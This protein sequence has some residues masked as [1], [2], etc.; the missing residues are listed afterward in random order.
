MNI[1]KE[2]DVI[3]LEYK[4][5][6]EGKYMIMLIDMCVSAINEVLPQCYK[7]NTMNGLRKEFVIN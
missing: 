7:T 5:L 2:Q 3:E 1:N 4:D 6:I